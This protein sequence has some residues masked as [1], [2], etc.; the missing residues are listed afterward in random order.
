M[1]SPRFLSSLSA[2]LSALR[3]RSLPLELGAVARLVISS[4]NA[5]ATDTSNTFLNLINLF[6][7]V[8]TGCIYTKM[9]F[10]I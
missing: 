3:R 1:A 9:K 7:L 8:V 10:Q 4:G 5:T 6:A 2:R